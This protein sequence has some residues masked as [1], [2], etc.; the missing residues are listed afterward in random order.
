MLSHFLHKI[1]HLSQLLEICYEH[2]KYCKDVKKTNFR[3]LT[4]QDPKCQITSHISKHF[5]NDVKNIK[6]I[7]TKP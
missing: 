1:F 5:F 6:E 2:H 3:L 7:T 4:S